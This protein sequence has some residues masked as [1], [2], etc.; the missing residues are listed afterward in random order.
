MLNLLRTR[1]SSDLFRDR[2]TLRLNC[3]HDDGNVRV[4]LFDANHALEKVADYTKLPDGTWIVEVPAL[5]LR[6]SGPSPT[7][8]KFRLFVEFDKK[9]AAWI[10][11]VTQTGS[12]ANSDLSPEI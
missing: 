9:I 10:F 3:L 7:D 8:C 2:L 4:M 1:T 11:A 5:R 12:S 6:A